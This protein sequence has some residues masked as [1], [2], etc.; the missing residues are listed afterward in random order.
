L[1]ASVPLEIQ[2]LDDGACVAVH[3]DVTLHTAFQ[4]IFRFEKG[5]LVPVACEAL[6]RVMRGSTPVLTDAWFGSLDPAAFRE[7]E[8]QLRRLHIRNARHIPSGQRRLFLNFD[9]RIP[10]TPASFETVL[11]ELGDELRAAGISPADVVCEITEA[12]T[13]NKAALTHFGYELRARGYMIAVDDFGARASHLGRVADLAPDIVKFDAGLVKRLMG[14]P[15]GIATLHMLI[16]KFRRD[17]I[18]SVLEG[19]EALREVG[20]AEDAGAAM[21]Q[22][23]VLAAPRLAGSEFAPWLAQYTPQPEEPAVRMVKQFR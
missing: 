21:V 4:P 6:I 13:T 3:G 18:H 1:S 17:G 23:Y 11:R 12:E 5:H 7:I 2:T 15:A 20:L 16:E 10:E 22:G 8:P 14:T 9:P 19:L